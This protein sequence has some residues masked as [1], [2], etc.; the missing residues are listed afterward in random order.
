LKYDQTI[1][2]VLEV[3]GKYQISS[4]PIILPD[5]KPQ[6][7]VDVLDI[8]AY[9]VKTSTKSLTDIIQGESF[10]IKTD[11]MKMMRKRAKDF[12][13]K[14][15]SE[16]IDISRRNP[17]F[18]LQED[19][20]VSEVMPIFQQGVHR[21]A[22]LDRLSPKIVG[23]VSQTDIIHQ[24]AQDPNVSALKKLISET[25]ILTG[26][27]VSVT[28]DTM[29]LDAFI[30]MQESGVSS[31][32]ILDAQGT[33]VGTVSA[34]DVKW[35]SRHED[36]RTLLCSIG[37]YV[38]DIRKQQGKSDHFVA[39]TQDSASIFDVVNLMFQEKVHR[40]FIVDEKRKP[41]GVISLTDII[42]EIGSPMT[43]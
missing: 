27:L 7:F 28:S 10:S 9:L 34:S 40:V 37:D 22:L 20:P 5:G 25:G 3:L 23:V 38:K 24:L 2:Q 32:A 21:V 8:L 15:L 4:A 43:A 36:F 1:H 16:V 19:Q 17:Y 39:C 18:A 42:R 30:R 14:Q 26:K 13:L 11:D 35:I 29:A 12:N 41:K 33:I 31:L 6:G